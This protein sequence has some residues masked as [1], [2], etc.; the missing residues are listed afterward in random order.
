MPSGLIDTLGHA[1]DGMPIMRVRP[2][3]SL[4]LLLAG[5]G[6]SE[7]APPVAAISQPVMHQTHHA[8]TPH[9]T[10]TVIG[11]D[12]AALIHSFGSPRLDIHDGD[13]H[14]LQWSGTA[15]IMDAYLYPASPGAPPTAA[16]V[17]TRRGD[18]RDVDRTQCI[19]ALRRN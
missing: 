2:T 7:I 18:G 14:K 13:A 5:C 6:E 12:A 17:E 16:Y 4:I 3:L 8:T 11:A 15:C 1:A 9:D 10:P 19:A